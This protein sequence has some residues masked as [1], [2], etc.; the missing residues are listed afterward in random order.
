MEHVFDEEQPY[1][2]YQLNNYKYVILLLGAAE[3]PVPTRR[4]GCRG[5]SLVLL[6]GEPIEISQ[7]SVVVV[8][9]SRLSVGVHEYSVLLERGSS[10][11]HARAARRKHALHAALRTPR[12]HTSNGE[13]RA[14]WHDWRT[15]LRRWTNRT[16]RLA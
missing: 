8:A 13:C 16:G 12:V 9:Q 10:A 4:S 3:S 6:D 2:R 7:R 14:V 5:N 1:V 15:A 11:Q